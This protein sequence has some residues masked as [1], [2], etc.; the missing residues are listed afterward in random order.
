MKPPG[1]PTAAEVRAK[2]EDAERAFLAATIALGEAMV[3]RQT[4]PDRDL[5][6]EQDAVHSARQ[7]VDQLKS[8]L[9]VV[10]ELEKAALAGTRSKLAEDQRRLLEKALK[11]LL[12]NSIVFSTSYQ[13]LVSSFRRMVSSGSEV[14]HLLFDVHRA[15]PNNHFQTSLSQTGLR[16]LGTRELNRLGL[17]LDGG[18]HPPGTSPV[19]SDFHRQIPLSLEREIRNLMAR[20]LA[21]APSPAPPT[22]GEG[23]GSSGAPAMPLPHSAASAEARP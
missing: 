11:D 15:Q 16:A 1:M 4:Y 9:P 23:S 10:E 14:S 22:S 6:P 20:I 19:P 5:T 7:T 2:I 18:V 21:S 12:R 3:V 17:R 13:N 8:M